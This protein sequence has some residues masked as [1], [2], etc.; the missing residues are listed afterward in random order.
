VSVINSLAREL[1][2]KIVY[3]GPGMSGKTTSLAHIHSSL[4]PSHRGDLISLATEGDR[5]LFFDF[6]PVHLGRV[7]DLDL[8]LQ[9]YTVPG[10]VFYAATRRLVLEGADGVVFVADSQEAAA[11]RNIE[12]LLDLRENL[13]RFGT[14]LEKLPFVIQ[15]NKRDLPTC[16]P[17]EELRSQL[18]T[19]NAEDF[20]TCASTGQGVQ[21]ALK[22]V[23]RR[24]IAYLSDQA[25]SELGGGSKRQA[26][27]LMP[28]NEG[29][30]D[31]RFESQVSDALLK[32]GSLTRSRVSDLGPNSRASSI[33]AAP[34]LNDLGRTSPPP[35]VRGDHKISSKPARVSNNQ[36]AKTIQAPPTRAFSFAALFSDSTLIHQVEQGIASGQFAEA[37]YRAGGGVSTILDALLGPYGAEGSATRAQLLGLDGHEYLKL[38]RLCSKPA[39]VITEEDALFALYVLIAVRVKEA[40]L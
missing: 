17:I 16:L 8:R 11:E 6:L 5:T 19:V 4:K 14:S 12:S 30:S 7:R 31:N 24:V 35:G 21:E 26:L 9:L 38:R 32:M 25:P 27:P 36:G 10:Q 18:N 39:S 33:P 37:V 1:S 2:A 22:A 28:K 34:E 15:Y 20:A 23:T 40:R 29:A 13:E 3:Y